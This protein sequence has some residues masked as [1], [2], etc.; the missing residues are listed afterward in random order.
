MVPLRT[1]S[2]AHGGP[3][4]S[5]NRLFRFDH[6]TPQR[7]VGAVA[8]LAAAYTLFA[9]LWPLRYSLLATWGVIELIFYVLYWRPRYAELNEQPHPHMPADVDGS[10]T[11]QRFL[12]FCNDLPK[13][14][15]Y[16]AYFSGWFKGADFGDI[17]RGACCCAPLRMHVHP[18]WQAA[19]AAGVQR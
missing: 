9:I 12:K 2:L 10:K 18:R 16:R 1:S 4:K 5:D 19:A 13:G 14:V 3:L 17:K 15:D 11:F 7:L 6:K 8:L